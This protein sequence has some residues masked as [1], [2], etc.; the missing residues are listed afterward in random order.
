MSD[1]DVSLKDSLE[2]KLQGTGRLPAHVRAAQLPVF[3]K[4][5]ELSG[6]SAESFIDALTQTSL[7]GLVAWTQV[8]LERLLLAAQRHNL[9]PL[10]REVFLV[11]GGMDPLEPAIVVVGVDGWS[12]ILNSHKQFAGMRFRE[13][14]ELL[15][16]LPAWV[17]CTMH[18]WDRKVATTVREYMAESRG[19]GAAWLTH[20][21]RMLRHKSMVQCARLAF[22]LVG[23][24]DEQEAESIATSRGVSKAACSLDMATGRPALGRKAVQPLG[25]EAVKRAIYGEAST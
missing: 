4:S 1:V 24:Y 12:R 9:N 10:G 16:G 7:S 8:D 2:Q 22:G 6:M 17:E 20:P 15:D 23:I 19:R 21:R 5:V 25:V 3:L 11:P 14:Q 13:S 18:R